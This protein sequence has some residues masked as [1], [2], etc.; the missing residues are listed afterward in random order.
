MESWRAAQLF[1][2]NIKLA[3]N[4][5]QD[6]N[7]TLYMLKRPIW[8]SPSFYITTASV[9]CIVHCFHRESLVRKKSHSKIN[10]MFWIL[11]A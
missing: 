10:Q 11:C 2:W 8:F 5:D 9:A 4:I 6:F 1:Y 3:N 7:V